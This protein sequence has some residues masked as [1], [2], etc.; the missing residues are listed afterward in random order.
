MFPEGHTYMKITMKDWLIVA[1]L[2]L[3][4]IALMVMAKTPA[5][6]ATVN[7]YSSTEQQIGLLELYTSEGC[8]SCPPADRWLSS[9]LQNEGLWQH[10]IPIALHVDYWD[11]IGW[12]DRFA[13]HRYSARQRQ[14]ARQ[15]AVPTVYTPGFVYNGAEWR[16]WRAGRSPDFSTHNTPGILQLKLDGQKAELIFAATQTTPQALHANLALLGFDLHTVVTAGE[17]R[18]KQLAQNFVVLGINQA[19]MTGENNLYSGHLDLPVSAMVAPRYAAVAW[20]NELNRQGP[21]QAVGGW[22]P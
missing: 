7:H 20:V 10:F 18:G 5:Q 17:N 14:Y 6:A 2:L 1:F 11:Y 3:A 22:L 8:S 12:K 16:Q 21:L 4:G 19:R 13:S 9:L 15:A